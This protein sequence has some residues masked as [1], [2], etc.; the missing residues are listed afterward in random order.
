MRTFE[1]NHIRRGCGRPRR[2]TEGFCRNDPDISSA[3]AE[4]SETGSLLVS[5]VACIHAP[6]RCA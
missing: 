4:R 2:P 6:Q 3:I 1:P 5:K